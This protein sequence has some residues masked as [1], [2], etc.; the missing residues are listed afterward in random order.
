[1]Y[2]LGALPDIDTDTWSLINTDVEFIQ[3]FKSLEREYDR[4]N[5]WINSP[6]GRITDG[7]AM[8]NTIRNS[9]K[10]VHTYNLGLAASMGAVLLISGKTVHAPADSIVMIHNAL[11]G[12]IGNK[13]EIR[14][15]AD[16]LEVYELAIVKMIAGKTGQSEGDIISKYF[17]GKDHF[18]LGED[19]YND[20]LI[21][22]LETYDT[23]L[24]DGAQNMSYD[25]II[26]L[27]SN[28]KSEQTMS[29]KDWFG[30]PTSSDEKQI[31]KIPASEL[32]QLRSD[33]EE[34]VQ[35]I[36]SLTEENENLRGQM[37]TL[38]QEKDAAVENLQKSTENHAAALKAE[39]DAHA[40]TQKA[41]D[42][43][44]AG[45]ADTHTEVNHAED[46]VNGGKQEPTSQIRKDEEKAKAQ[47][48]KIH[49][50]KSKTTK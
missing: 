41:F 6:G 50:S 39:Q 47:G 38:S 21:D 16:M 15:Y 13:Q 14:D 1:M 40:A 5:I 29:L 24:P 28:H 36:S 17:D 49:E 42:D 20:G 45:S 9:K 10:D 37:N 4:I 44:K 43:F 23:E 26:N 31:V 3:E 32:N 35:Q 22:K 34:A 7:M 2:V 46:T 33:A 30:T 27:F 8:I 25:Q 18:M 12:V 48:K 19:A 11:G